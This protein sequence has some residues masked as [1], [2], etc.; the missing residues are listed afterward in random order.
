LQII[1]NFAGLANDSTPPFPN[2]SAAFNI[3]HASANYD[4]PDAGQYY[5][6]FRY[7]DISFFVMDT[8][9]YRSSVKDEDVGSRTMLGHKQLSALYHWLNKVYYTLIVPSRAFL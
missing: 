9:R 4:S 1:N 2:A 5:Y 3:Y 8:R 7:G 6:D